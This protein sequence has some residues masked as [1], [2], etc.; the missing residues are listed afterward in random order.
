M[1]SNL[2][3]FQFAL[4]GNASRHRQFQTPPPPKTY[5]KFT[6]FGLLSVFLG[7]ADLIAITAKVKS[8]SWSSPVWSSLHSLCLS[9]P[10]F[11]VLCTCEDSE[12]AWRFVLAGSL[13]GTLCCRRCL[14]PLVEVLQ[15]D[16]I[17]L[18]CNGRPKRKTR[19]CMLIFC[20]E[21]NRVFLLLR[22]SSILH[23]RIAR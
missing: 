14:L 13:P 17:P 11:N 18:L 3:K 2:A 6:K 21:C 12:A 1:G 20:Y 15:H 5:T 10:L 7:A 22:N 9:K 16:R 4:R 19:S 8:W 23:F